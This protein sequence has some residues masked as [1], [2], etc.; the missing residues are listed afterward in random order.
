MVFQINRTQNGY[1]KV[2]KNGISGKVMTFDC[3]E[4]A[5]TFANSCLANARCEDKYQGRKLPKYEVIE[6]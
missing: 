1:T 6:K 2:L 5:H 3:R 4:D